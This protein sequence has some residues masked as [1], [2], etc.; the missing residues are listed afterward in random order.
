MKAEASSSAKD[1]GKNQKLMLLRR[2]NAM[3]GA[4]IISG[5]IQLP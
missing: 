3:S 5:I 2:G 1:A 4:P